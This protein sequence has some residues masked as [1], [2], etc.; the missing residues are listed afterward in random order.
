MARS[1]NK[2]LVGM[3]EDFIEAY[4][5]DEIRV[6]ADRYP[7]EQR[8]LHIDWEDIYRF[9]PDLADDFINQPE[10]IQRFAEEAVR[11]YEFE[12]LEKAPLL[13][14][15]HV[16]IYNLPETE[17]PAI[18][19]IRARHTGSLVE[20]RGIVG[21]IEEVKPKVEEAAFEC[22]V[23][24]TITRIPQSGDSL[25]E[26]F[27]CQGC[28]KNEEFTIVPERSKLIDS[29]NITISDPA[30]SSAK[31]PGSIEAILKDDITGD[32]HEGDFVDV[33]GIVRLAQ[34]GTSTSFGS[35]LEAISVQRYDYEQREDWPELDESG[36]VTFADEIDEFVERSRHILQTQSDLDE[37]NTK[38]KII[39]PFVEL[40]GWNLF[41]DDVILEYPQGDTDVNDQVDYALL[42]DGQPR[43][44]VEAKRPN[45]RLDSDVGQLKKYMRLHRC[46]WGLLTNGER[47]IILR[48]HEDLDLDDIVREV[49]CQLEHLPE[50]KSAFSPL[51][52]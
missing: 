23:C 49:D 35:S 5:D 28:E 42:E 33:T 34:E 18:R 44:C 50:R 46:E 37:T 31:P 39:T 21:D 38:A 22:E 43:V 41:S 13:G 48:D 19:D 3:F 14:Q 52:K 9:D 51:L 6:L 29:Q 11:L 36:S 1:S 25:S 45:G 2:E 12:D 40:L 26:P 32:V 16:R 8:S 17:S 4:Y 47:F 30:G 15:A 10:Q 20:V 24:G 7:N 27:E